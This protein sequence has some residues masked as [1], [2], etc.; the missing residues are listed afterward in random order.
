[1]EDSVSDGFGFACSGAG[2][3]EQGSFCFEDSLLLLFIKS[4]EMVH[5][6]ILTY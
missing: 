3:N 1:M 4:E 5:G 6:A 2:Q